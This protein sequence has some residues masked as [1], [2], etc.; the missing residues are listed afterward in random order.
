MVK[1]WVV[2]LNQLNN[3]ARAPPKATLLLKLHDEPAA[4]VIVAIIGR[5]VVDIGKAAIV[6]VAAIEPV[7]LAKICFKPSKFTRKPFS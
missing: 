1:C 4:E 3:K 5:I 2:G 6:A 7:G